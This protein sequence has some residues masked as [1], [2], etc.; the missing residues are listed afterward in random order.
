[1]F[2]ITPIFLNMQEKIT[3]E[4]THKE[5]KKKK[6]KISID[7]PKFYNPFIVAFSFKFAYILLFFN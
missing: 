2:V 7:K 3:S 5:V 1:M 4:D 6:K